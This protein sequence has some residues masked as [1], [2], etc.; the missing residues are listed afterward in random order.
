MDEAVLA[1][2]LMLDRRCEKCQIVRNTY[3]DFL[4]DWKK[5]N[6]QL[7]LQGCVGCFKPTPEGVEY[8]FWGP[9]EGV[10]ASYH[11]LPNEW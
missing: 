5:I 7:S 11:P 6:I 8:Q 3:F 9:R 1:K 10:C 4:D 2:N